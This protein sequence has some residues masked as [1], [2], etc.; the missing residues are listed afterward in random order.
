M[1][2]AEKQEQT[3]CLWTMRAAYW[4][5]ISSLE[6]FYFR[7]MHTAPILV[8][9]PCSASRCRKTIELRSASAAIK[10]HRKGFICRL[11]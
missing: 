5:F 7:C 8:E 11:Y 1:L 9:I 3:S 10:A 6:H 4:T 2:V